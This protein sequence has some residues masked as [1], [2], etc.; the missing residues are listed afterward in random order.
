MKPE[1]L[2]PHLQ[3]LATYPYPESDQ[4]MPCHLIP[5]SWRSFLLLYFYLRLGLSNDLFAWGLST[6]TLYAPLLSRLGVTFPAHLI[7]L[8]LITPR[9]KSLSFSHRTLQP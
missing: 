7:L 6:K 5:I 4:S 3:A 8:V 1:I 9:R 2:F